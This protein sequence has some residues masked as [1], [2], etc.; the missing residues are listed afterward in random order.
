MT[1]AN[2]RREQILSGIAVPPDRTAGSAE[3]RSSARGLPPIGMGRPTIG[4][5]VALTKDVSQ[6]GLS[7]LAPVPLDV[8]DS[9]P[10]KLTGKKVVGARIAWKRGA[11]VGLSFRCDTSDN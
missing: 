2:S 3:R 11:L 10:V 6:G 1:Q 7:A 8:G 9:V 4:A 5:D